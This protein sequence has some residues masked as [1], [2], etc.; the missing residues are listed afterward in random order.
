LEELGHSDIPMKD[1]SFRNA[2]VENQVRGCTALLNRAARR[3]LTQVPA[4]CV[5]HDWWMYL[6]ISV[7]GKVVY[8]S[9]SRI[10][11]RQHGSNVFGIPTGRIATWTNKIR[12]F[13]RDGGCNLVVEQAEAFRLLHGSSLAEEHRRVLDRFLQ[14]KG[15]WG[16]LCYALS[17]DVYRQTRRDH[18][19]LKVRLALGI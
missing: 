19:I 8:D 2:L 7:F 4:A 5:S 11:Y 14:N 1:L 17:C 12:Q 16:R 13:L 18:Y 15:F 6:V 3:L 10:L 9:E